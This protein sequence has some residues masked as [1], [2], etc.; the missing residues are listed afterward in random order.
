MATFRRDHAPTVVN[1]AITAASRPRRRPN[2]RPETVG[3]VALQRD[4]L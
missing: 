3:D 1:L 2:D 4:L